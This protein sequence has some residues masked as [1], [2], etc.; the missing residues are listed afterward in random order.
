MNPDKQTIPDDEI[1]LYDP[2]LKN[3]A[4]GVVIIGS[5]P[6]NE[7]FYQGIKVLN[8]K[9]MYLNDLKN[10]INDLDLKINKNLVLNSTNLII[11]KSPAIYTVISFFLGLFLSIVLVLFKKNCDN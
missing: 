6:Q 10:K 4:K 8:Q 1:D 5:F 3:G 11:S 9:L 7:L 2:I